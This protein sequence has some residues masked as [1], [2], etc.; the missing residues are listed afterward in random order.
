MR[1]T[2]YKSDQLITVSVELNDG[3]DM[4]FYKIVYAHNSESERMALSDD[5]KNLPLLESS[6]G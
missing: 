5:L 3:A 2:F 6:P 4:F 1:V